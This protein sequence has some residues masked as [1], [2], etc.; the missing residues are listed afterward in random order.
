MNARHVA[1][2]NV[3]ATVIYSSRTEHGAQL[4]RFSVMHVAGTNLPDM[5]DVGLFC[6]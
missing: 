3:C 6:G 2:V 5:I 1:L 4:R